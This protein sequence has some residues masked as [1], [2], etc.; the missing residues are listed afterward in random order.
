MSPYYKAGSS[1]SLSDNDKS[2]IVAIY[3]AATTTPKQHSAPSSQ[4]RS[5]TTT[6]TE[7]QNNQASQ[8]TNPQEVQPQSTCCLTM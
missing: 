6:P 2:R 5:N 7:P 8:E 1:F 4:T 3:G